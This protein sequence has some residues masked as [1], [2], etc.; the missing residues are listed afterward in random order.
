MR[1][2]RQRASYRILFL[3]AAS[4]LLLSACTGQRPFLQVQF[5][6]ANARGVDL[7]K[8]TLQATAREEHMRYTD[9]GEATTRDLKILR[10]AANNMHTDGGLIYVGIE[11]DGFGLEGG[12]LGLNPYDISVGFSPDT[13]AARAFSKRVVARLEQHWALKVVPKNSGAFPNPECSQG[14]GN[15]T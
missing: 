11:A 15:A 14:N 1:V 2:N 6:V 7:F 5:C 9:V 13:V 8:K 12:N 4:T 10:P 3:F